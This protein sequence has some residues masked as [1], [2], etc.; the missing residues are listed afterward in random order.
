MTYDEAIARV[1]QIVKE[2]EQSEALSMEVYKAKAKEAKELL[3]FCEKSFV[4]EMDEYMAV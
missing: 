4:R 2:L 1:E 3:D